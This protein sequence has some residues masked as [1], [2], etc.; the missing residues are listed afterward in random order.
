M[1]E[2]M[3]DFFGKMFKMAIFVTVLGLFLTIYFELSVVYS[4]FVSISLVT[5]RELLN[6]SDSFKMVGRVY[7]AF[8]V[9]YIGMDV[10]SKVYEVLGHLS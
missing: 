4:I 1:R 8:L 6:F 10:L 3:K 2:D 9:M 5:I 7:F